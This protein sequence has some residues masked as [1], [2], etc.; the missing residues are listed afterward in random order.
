M[1]GSAQKSPDQQ[2][3]RQ[4]THALPC[5]QC[6][7]QDTPQVL[8][9]LRGRGPARVDCR[10]SGRAVAERCSA[11]PACLPPLLTPA[12]QCCPPP[13]AAHHHQQVGHGHQL[14]G[15]LHAQPVAQEHANGAHLQSAGEGGGVGVGRGQGAG[16]AGCVACPMWVYV[17]A[18]A[19]CGRVSS[20]SF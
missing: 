13:P 12:P 1:S 14:A 15:A 4:H 9:Q 3:A 2:Q 10:L 20:V 6:A 7:K 8:L 16:R 11:A 17:N 18:A 19:G 5:T